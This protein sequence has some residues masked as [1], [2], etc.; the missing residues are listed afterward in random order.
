MGA[1]KEPHGGEL[2]SLYLSPEEAAQEKAKAKDYPSWD[3]TP[4]QFCDLELMLNGAFSPLEGFLNK[5]DYDSVVKKM[6]LANGVLWPIPITLDVSDDFAAE[7]KSGQH[8]ALRDPEGVLIATLQVGDIWTPDKKAEAKSVFGTTDEMHP[9]TFKPESDVATSSYERVPSAALPEEP[10]PESID[11]GDPIEEP[12]DIPFTVWEHLRVAYRRSPRRVATMFG[13]TVI[14][15]V[16]I[17]LLARAVGGTDADAAV[18]DEATEIAAAEKSEAPE[19][20]K[21]AEVEAKKPAEPQAAPVE[22]AKPPGAEKAAAVPKAWKYFGSHK[23]NYRP[24]SYF[25]PPTGSQGRDSMVAAALAEVYL[26]TG[27]GQAL[28]DLKAFVPDLENLQLDWP[29]SRRSGGGNFWFAPPFLARLAMSLPEGAL[30]RYE[31]ALTGASANRADNAR[32]EID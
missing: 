6:R 25:N 15:I 27:H 32:L 14:A 16:G 31:H 29:S 2:K 12:D 30:G 21:L 11:A 24:T 18:V 1:F 17:V 4:R 7:L 3:L 8:I 26:T 9:V 20:E 19:T 28:T 10:E 22:Q 13:G 23:E 5:D